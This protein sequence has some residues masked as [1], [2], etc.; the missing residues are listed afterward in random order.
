MRREYFVYSAIFHVLVALLSIYGLP[1][2]LDDKPIEETPLVVD[3]V[4]IGPKTNP[5]PKQDVEP[6]PEPPKPEDKPEQAA[7]PPPPKPA[8]PPPPAPTPPPPPAPPPKPEPPPPAPVPA[9][10]P[11]KPEPKPQPKPEPPKPEPPKPEKK[12]KP[13]PDVDLDSLLKTV[14][15]LKPQP[16]KTDATSKEKPKD[17][18]ADLLNA[19]DKVKPSSD[20]GKQPKPQNVKG[21]A[22]NN[23]NEPVSM[24]EMDMIK[25][26]IIPHWQVPAG[27]KDAANLIIPIHVM[28][29]PDGT[30]TKAEIVDTLRYNTDSFYRAAADSARR[31][32]LTAS[33][34]KAPPTKYDQWKDFTFRFNPKDMVGQ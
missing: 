22:Q 25:A 28:L 27:A 14:D 1:F 12:P 8:P 30:V 6:Q 3:I 34:L 13:Q 7:P 2:F 29:D 24:T 10:A 33:P 20:Q 9:P 11:P 5:P 26:Q 4:P 21:S 15:K 19:A 16:Q 17:Q 31:A 23:P 18:L 32:V